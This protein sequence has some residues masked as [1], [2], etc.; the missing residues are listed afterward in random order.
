[1]QLHIPDAL[2]PSRVAQIVEKFPATEFVFLSFML[3]GLL[4]W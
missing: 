1:M 4:E 2:L 3:L